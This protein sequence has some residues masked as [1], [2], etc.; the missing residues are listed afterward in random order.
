MNQVRKD[1][2][3][4]GNGFSVNWN[5]IEIGAQPFQ[6]RGIVRDQQDHREDDQAG[7]LGTKSGND[8]VRPRPEQTRDPGNLPRVWWISSANVQV[9]SA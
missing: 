3:F 6:Q 4:Q 1:N 8:Q 5:F 9:V 7:R 2:L